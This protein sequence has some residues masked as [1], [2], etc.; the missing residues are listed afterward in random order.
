MDLRQIR[1]AL[2]GNNAKKQFITLT[3]LAN[4]FGASQTRTVR[5]YVDGLQTVGGKYYLINEVAQR[6]REETT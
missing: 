6:I 4:V 3:E 2:Q 1:S 5:K